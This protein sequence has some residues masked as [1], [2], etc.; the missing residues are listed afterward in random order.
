MLPSLSQ[1]QRCSGER[2]R[3]VRPW[4]QS[5][6]RGNEPGRIN[7]ASIRHWWR[8]RLCFDWPGSKVSGAAAG[9]ITP[10]ARSS[11]RGSSDPKVLRRGL[12]P[13][14]GFLV[15]AWRPRWAC[16]SRLARP[17][18]CGRRLLAAGVGLNEAVSLGGNE[19][20]YCTESQVMHSLKGLGVVTYAE[21][22]VGQAAFRAA[23]P[24]RPLS[25]TRGKERNGG[26]RI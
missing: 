5:D 24:G 8:R 19:P 14:F 25:T 2:K 22:H 26:P 6:R 10:A 12:A 3:G 18:R 11:R 21:R 16:S 17:Q 13:I 23:D 15:A 20:F 9:A 4:H 7:Q 1:E